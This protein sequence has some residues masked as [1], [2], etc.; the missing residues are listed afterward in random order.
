MEWTTGM[1][2]WTGLSYFP[3]LDKFLNLFLE[4]YILKFTC[5]WVLWMIVIMTIVGY[6]SVFITVSKYT[7]ENIVYC[8]MFEVE[9]FC[10]FLVN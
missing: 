3:F 2:H 9:K 8:K 10:G 6:H 7:F 5:S 4:A 1:E